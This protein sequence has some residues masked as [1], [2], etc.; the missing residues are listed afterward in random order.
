MC[1]KKEK[2]L[3]SLGGKSY[4]HCIPPC[5]RRAFLRSNGRVTR[6]SYEHCL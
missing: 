3:F 6:E 4:S 5:S 2:G 1:Q